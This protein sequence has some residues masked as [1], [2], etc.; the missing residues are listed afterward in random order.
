M[1]LYINNLNLD[2]LPNI[3]KS[4]E[5]FSFKTETYI[6]VY[7]SDGIYKIDNSDITKLVSNDIDIKI[8]ENYYNDFSIIVDPSYFTSEASYQIDT[9]HISIPI[10]KNIFKMNKNSSIMLA[11]ECE[12]KQD[13]NFFKKNNTE[14]AIVPTDMYFELPNNTDINNILVKN[15]IIEFLS[16]LN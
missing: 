2:I 10:K 7:S 13:H 3:M 1:K 9:D 15:E 6:Q 4:F 5:D 12:I 11:I 14:N 8:I 16:L